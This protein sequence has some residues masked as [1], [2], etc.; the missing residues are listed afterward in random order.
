ML[1]GKKKA[2]K[3]VEFYAL[4]IYSENYIYKAPPCGGD[5]EGVVKSKSW[6]REDQQ[7]S[8]TYHHKN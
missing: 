2:M 3:L 7:S 1:I 8:N 5:G 4:S 6:S